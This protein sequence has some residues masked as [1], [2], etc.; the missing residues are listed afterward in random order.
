MSAHGHGTSGHVVTQKP[1][2][3][4][5]TCSDNSCTVREYS[6][7]DDTDNISHIAVRSDQNTKPG[8]ASRKMKT[9]TAQ[10]TRPDKLKDDRISQHKPDNLA[11]RQ[12]LGEGERLTN[13]KQ[14]PGRGREDNEILG[15][16]N[17][18]NSP[19]TGVLPGD[20]AA[21]YPLINSNR[22]NINLS[23][24]DSA[25]SLRTQ[26]RT[27]TNRLRTNPSRNRKQA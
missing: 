27:R 12:S 13:F 15:S 11:L 25:L 19:P 26:A 3:V 23:E 8:H 9:R 1:I 5:Y 2:L 14:E 4:G 6:A 22:S 17:S 24:N 20:Q 7:Q 16:G 21:P 18:Q 10:K